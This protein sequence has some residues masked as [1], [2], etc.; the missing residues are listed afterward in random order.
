MYT[1]TVDTGHELAEL[2]EEEWLS[3][4]LSEFITRNLSRYVGYVF[5]KIA[6]GSRI[7]FQSI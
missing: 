4:D 6:P 3:L 2:S 7:N 5:K 1:R